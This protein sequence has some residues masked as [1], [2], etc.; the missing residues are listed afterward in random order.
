MKNDNCVKPFFNNPNRIIREKELCQMISRS[1][2]SI[3]RDILK[4]DFPI[5]IRMGARSKGW[6]LH[7]IET[8]INDQPRVI[9]ENKNIKLVSGEKI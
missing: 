7:E 3:R 4:G 9:I 6:K 8:W 2:S 5:P 1:R